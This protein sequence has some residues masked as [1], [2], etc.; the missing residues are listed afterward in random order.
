VEGVLSDLVVVEWEELEEVQAVEEEE[1]ERFK[2]PF[3]YLIKNKKIVS[4]KKN[5]IKTFNFKYL[6]FIF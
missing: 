6:F 2:V 5:Q 1:E 3:S 4:Y